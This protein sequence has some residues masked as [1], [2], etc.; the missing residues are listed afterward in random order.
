MNFDDDQPDNP[1]LGIVNAFLPGFALMAMFA[2]TVYWL[3]W[4]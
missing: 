3:V 2:T 4:P 1:A